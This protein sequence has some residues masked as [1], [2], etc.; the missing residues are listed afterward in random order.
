MLMKIYI[1]WKKK[2]LKKFLWKKSYSK[3]LL[4]LM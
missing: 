4:N 2:M 3:A 1:Y